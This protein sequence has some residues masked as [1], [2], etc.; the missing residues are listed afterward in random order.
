M[1]TIDNIV[2][3]MN[4]RNIRV[5]ELCDGVGISTGHF[6][7]WK[8]G[9]SSPKLQSLIKIA[10]FL[11]VSLDHIMG[12]PITKRAPSADEEADDFVFALSGEVRELTPE[13]RQQVSDF[14]KFV[15]ARHRANDEADKQGE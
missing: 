8:S 4:E 5:K 1:S 15:R 11:G 10:D 9:R 7:D 14:V 6:Y 3:L 13:E 2:S 12:G